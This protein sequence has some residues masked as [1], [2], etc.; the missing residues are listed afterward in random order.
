[1]VQMTDTRLEAFLQTPRYAVFGT[2]AADGPPQLSTVWFLYEEGI[3]YFGVERRSIKCRNLT[4]DPR[5]AC[6]INGE[7]PDGQTVIVHGHAELLEKSDPTVDGISWRITRRYHETDEAAREYEA[8]VKDLDSVL[9]RLTPKKIIAID[10]SA[11][12][13]PRSDLMRGGT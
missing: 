4:R 11:Y 8:L 7:H 1:M 12:T 6:C 10:Y 13:V 2:N 9:V 5:A 3:F